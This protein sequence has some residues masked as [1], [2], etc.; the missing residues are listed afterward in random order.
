M[1]CPKGHG[2][3]ATE[4]QEDHTTDWVCVQ[5]GFRRYEGQLTP[6]EIIEDTRRIPKPDRHTAKRMRRYDVA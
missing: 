5:C 2:R 4:P 1:F 3:L 6:L